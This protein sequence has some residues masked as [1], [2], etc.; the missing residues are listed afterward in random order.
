MEQEPRDL[1]K[2]QQP[3]DYLA[4]QPS[5][6]TTDGT[7]FFRECLNVEHCER[8]CP[9]NQFFLAYTRS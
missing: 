3:R 4:V 6:I 8:S 7:V 9:L 1:K 5:Y 2:H